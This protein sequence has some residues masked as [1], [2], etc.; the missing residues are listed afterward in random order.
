MT[1]AL[2]SMSSIPE[3]LGVFFLHFLDFFGNKFDTSKQGINIINRESVFPLVNS[4]EYAVT[5]DPVNFGNNTTR[6]SFRIEEVLKAFAQVYARLQEMIAKGKNK[7]L[8]KQAF[9]KVNICAASI[10]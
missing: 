6:A 2:N 4:K 3:D 9:K 1:A 8:L 7:N 10:D 5:I